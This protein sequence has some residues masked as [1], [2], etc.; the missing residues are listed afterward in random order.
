M[1]SGH[2]KNRLASV[3]C[4]H[5]H[6]SAS[7]SMQNGFARHTK[8]VSGVLVGRPS[9]IWLYGNLYNF[10]VVPCWLAIT[11]LFRVNKDQ[12]GRHLIGHL[13]IRD[14]PPVLELVA[15]TLNKTA[16]VR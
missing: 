11:S 12:H 13:L 14:H 8:V 1:G 7:A 4:H 15:V 3:T 16:F 10:C 5:C 2:L 6:F 9:H